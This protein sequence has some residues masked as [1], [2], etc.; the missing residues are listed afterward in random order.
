MVTRENCRPNRPLPAFGSGRWAFARG[1]SARTEHAARTPGRVNPDG[2]SLPLQ[3]LAAF[4]SEKGAAMVY[5]GSSV[6]GTDL[7]TSVGLRAPPASRVPDVLSAATPLVVEA[8][9][10]SYPAWTDEHGTNVEQLAAIVVTALYEQG[11]LATPD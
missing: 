9:V 11:L 2:G 6:V 8:L 5:D 10:Q 1:S 4:Q 3:T 7:P